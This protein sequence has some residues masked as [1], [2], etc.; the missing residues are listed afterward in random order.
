MKRILLLFIVLMTAGNV[1]M[2]TDKNK[3]TEKTPKKNEIDWISFDEAEKRMQKEPRK[4]WIDVYTEWCGW[5]K[6][7]DKKVF[8]HPEVIKYINTKYYAIKFDAERQDSFAFAGKK[9]GFMPEY[10][11]NGLAVQLMGGQM[12]YP[13]SIFME[14][15]FQNPAPIPGYHPVP[16]ME[17]IL[18]FLGEGVYKNT[19]YEDY[20]KTFTPAWKEILTPAAPSAH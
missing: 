4:V 11:A 16:E 13:T 15:N 3:K 2:A 8:S 12:S 5:C 9:W 7:L 14:E 17:G 6:V 18:K 1:A 19:K 10:K 20:M